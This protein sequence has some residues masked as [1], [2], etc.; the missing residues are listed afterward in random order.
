MIKIA[1]V[2]PKDSDSFFSPAE[3]RTFGGA[4]VQLF[5]IAGELKKRK[6]I[7]TYCLVS[8]YPGIKQ[9]PDLLT[10]FNNA[11]GVFT[12]ILKFHGKLKTL[13]P[14][15]VIQ[16]GLTFF[17]CLLALYCRISG[18]KFI[19]MFAHN[20]EPEGHYQKNNKRCMPFPLL[21]K[22]SYLLVCQSSDQISMVNEKYRGKT[23]LMKSMYPVSRI[24]KKEPDMI[25]WVSRIEKWK[26]PEV[27]IRLA[28]KFSNH[29]FMMIAP[30][31]PGKEDYAEKIY[32]MVWKYKNII[33]K[34]YVPFTEIDGYFRKSKIFINSSI[35]EGFPNTFVQAAKNGTPI[36]SLNVNPDNFLDNFRCGFSCGGSIDT[37]IQKI[38]LLL[39]DKKLYKEMSENAFSYAMENHDI[40]NNIDLFLSYIMNH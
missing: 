16:R 14:D 21:L 33:L 32:S 20:Y 36:V 39:K 26:Q 31:V 22:Y 8:E 28:E 10:T 23:I 24:S 2:F 25:L 19:F 34:K 37:A 4:N 35:E 15:F 13:K 11:D 17:S 40:K 1:I 29:K 9:D 3:D 38:E 27:F 6:N 5:Q 7:S 12:K 18:I 30:T